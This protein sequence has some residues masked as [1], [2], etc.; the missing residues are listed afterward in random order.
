[1]T[2][3]RLALAALALLVLSACAPRREPPAPAPDP[4]LRSQA[5]I[6]SG[7][8]AFKAKDFEG[9]ARRYASA[10]AIKPDDPAA[11]YG[12]GMALSRLGRDDEAREAYAKARAL[13]GRSGD[14]LAV[15]H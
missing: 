6:D 12:L 8:V 11:F 2:P 9:A 4:Q 1:M 3:P 14:S 15:T 13:M 10:V 5:L 7:N